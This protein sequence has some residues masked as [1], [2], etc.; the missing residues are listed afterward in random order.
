MPPPPDKPFTAAE[1]NAYLTDN[2]DSLSMSAENAARALENLSVAMRGGTLKKEIDAG[3]VWQE[4]EYCARPNKLRYETCKS[5]GA[6]LRINP[7]ALSLKIGDHTYP[8]EL[9]ES[10]QPDEFRMRFY[11]T[12]EMFDDDVLG[13]AWK[14]PF[15][16][17]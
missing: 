14:F 13:G 7:K 6:P 16:L 10:L 1:F 3:E 5:C 12:Q 17:K 9:D 2:F 4:C 15:E 8:V 11:A